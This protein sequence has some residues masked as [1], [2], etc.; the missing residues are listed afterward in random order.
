VDLKDNMKI[1]VL[2][3]NYAY[4]SGFETSWGFSCLLEF[5]GNAILFDTGGRDDILERNMVRSEVNPQEIDLIFISHFHYDHTGGIAALQNAGN[6]LPVYINKTFSAD[7]KKKIESLDYKI[8][9]TTEP[10]EIC[11]NVYT[12]GDIDGPVSE[13]AMVIKT[14]AGL[15]L[16]TGCAHPGIGKMARLAKKHFNGEL[17]LVMGGF[18]LGQSSEEAV[19]K[20]AAEM[21]R[22]GVRFI[23]PSHCT[24]DVARAIFK[25]A[26]GDDYIES[27]VGKVF[28]VG[29]FRRD[30]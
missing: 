29:N 16:I 1:T 25:R 22:L 13:Q 30:N 19:A 26:F 9:E 20:I 24:G 21:K 5:N 4:K 23:A 18:H 7:V 17:L 11:S 12:T 28:E 15:I 2:F 10:Q 8:V 3:D 27:G 6:G 14:E